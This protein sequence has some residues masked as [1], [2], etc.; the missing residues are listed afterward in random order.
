MYLSLTMSVL[1]SLCLALIEGVRSNAIRLEAECIMD[2]GMDSILAEY[3]R[4]LFEQYNLFAI[5]SSYGGTTA[6]K[7][8]VGQHLQHYIERNMSMEDI[9]LE[10]LLYRDF[11]AMEPEEIDVTR[12]SI[13]TDN[14]GAV[15]R[16]K[17]VEAIEDDVGLS[18]FERLKDWMQTV[19][20][21]NLTNTDIAGQK[22]QID[23][24]I[25]KYNGREVEVTP[26]VFWEI[27]I[28]NPTI[29]LENNRK[30]G[31]LACVI[32]D[33]E[34]L[35]DKSINQDTLIGGRMSWGNFNQGSIPVEE[36]NPSRQL[37]ERFL[38]QEYLFRYMGHYGQEKDGKALSY[39]LEYLLTGKDSD[40]L[41]LSGVVDSLTGIREAANA[42]YLL[43]DEEK[44][45]EAK[46]LAGI[47]CGL[48][49][50]P[51]L[52]ELVKYSLLLAWSFAESL[53]D[54][55]VLLQGG[56]VPLMKTQ[57]TWYYS[58]ANALTGFQITAVTDNK[59]GLSYEDY[60]RILCMLMQEDTLT[61][62]AMN[63]VE[64]NIRK[65]RKNRAFRMDACFVETEAGMKV[66]SAYGY[67]YEI[68]RRKGYR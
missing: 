9:F 19:E 8:N 59:G 57:D 41:N 16:K 53:H 46:L 56:R 20:I 18:L 4:E 17:A 48:F 32:S 54:V 26:G 55:E 24:E 25:E 15:F 21:H 67:S 23:E 39:E 44:C 14:N 47:L 29:E 35:S 65:T 33:V 7:A 66:T 30:K 40:V 3:H 13:M 31:A 64:A 43:T 61:K 58:L 6:G 60:L 1:L 68:T 49:K 5:D 62:R 2:I 36:S 34:A 38:F 27:Q 22:Q 51:E 37:L 10:S 63:L 50:V 11:L 42:I 52:T 45:G 12:V 28:E